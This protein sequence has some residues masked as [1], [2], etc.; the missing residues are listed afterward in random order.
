MFERPVWS[1]ID[2]SAVKKNVALIKGSLKPQVKFCAVVKA[3]AY[4]HGA[5]PVAGA[6]L[7]AG[8]DRLA[9]ALLSE[10]IELRQAGFSVPIQVLGYTPPHQARTVA[11][12]NIAQ[13]VYSLEAVQA[14]AAAGVESGKAVKVHIKVDT[15]MGRIGILPE[16]A[17]E[18]AS[19][20]AN[21]PGVELEG[22]FSHFATADAVDK[23][24]AQEQYANFEA[25][26]QRIRASGITVPIRHM[27][28]SAA[29]L[30]MPETHLDMVRPGIILYGLWPSAESKRSLALTPAMQLKAQVAHVKTVGAGT[31]ISYGRTYTARSERRIATLPIGYAD[32]WTRLLSGKTDVLI[33][34]CRAPLV[35]RICMD[36][37]MV[38]VSS[39]PAVQAGDTA[40]LFGTPELPAD[41]VA[42]AIG[43]INYELVC[44]VS[45]RVPRVY[46]TT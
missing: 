30:E 43:T 13:T 35:G 34:G 8:A 40:T 15:G 20:V 41:E 45:K 27:A 42:A 1:E 25:A 3:D 38:D 14:L 17:G 37:C 9:V 16:A 26:L 10:A 39:I 11:A 21:M 6:V 28:N 33:H 4:G 32:G 2:L 19:T 46:K 23:T 44:M 31:S 5:V 7:S 18:F 12:Y 24:Y 22:V 29:T 36:Q